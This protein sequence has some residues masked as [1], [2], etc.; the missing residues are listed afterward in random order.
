M[1]RND[2]QEVMIFL[3]EDL[4]RPWVKGRL[5]D[6]D[7]ALKF[8]KAVCDYCQRFIALPTLNALKEKRQEQ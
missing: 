3:H 7:F 1:K 6:I 8:E 2:F 5:T 4:F